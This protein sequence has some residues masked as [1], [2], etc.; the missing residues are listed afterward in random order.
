MRC[1]YLLVKKETA[2]IKQ[3]LDCD[4]LPIILKVRDKNEK[5]S[6]FAHALIKSMIVDRKYDSQVR[7]QLA[8]REN[9]LQDK[10]KLPQPEWVQVG[11][12]TPAIQSVYI[13]PV[14]AGA[15]AQQLASLQRSSTAVQLQVPSSTTNIPTTTSRQQT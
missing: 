12:P 6:K 9:L 7:Q 4:G 11:K 13:E 5:A 10:S 1:C 2:F 8:G 14:E 3:I 15:R